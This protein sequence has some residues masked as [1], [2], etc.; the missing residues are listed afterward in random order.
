[1]FKKL[2]SLLLLLLFVVSST[3]FGQLKIGYMNSQEVLSQMPER[4]SVQQQLNTF[5]QQKRQE[6]QQRTAAFQDSVAAYQQNQASMSQAQIQQEE[7]QLTEMENS[8]RQFQQSIQQQIQ[9]RRAS[10]L[11]PL[12]DRMNEAIATVAENNDLDFVLNEATSRGEQVV[13]YSESEQLNITDDVLEQINSTS[14][15]N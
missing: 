5:I 14:A 3:A 11:Q 7:Q 12:Y 9:R 1:M 10:L 15:Q 6:L 2:G 13:Y 4:S 8:M